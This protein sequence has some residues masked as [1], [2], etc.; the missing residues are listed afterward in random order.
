[1]ARKRR[2]EENGPRRQ[3]RPRPKPE[4]K[5]ELPDR[6][7]LE[8]TLRQF[9]GG[10]DPSTLKGQAEELLAQAFE[11]TDPQRKVELARKA[12]NLWP[13]CADAYVLLAE[14]ARSRKEAL[15]LYQQGVEAGQ[16]AL[17]P[18]VFEQDAGDFWGLLD[19]R[20]Y[21]RAREG[22]ANALWTAG[23]RQ[24][25]VEHLQEML[26]LNPHDNQGVRYTLARFLL[27]LDRD[28]D[29][30]HLL[31][32][33]PEE[34]SATWAYTEALLAFRQ[35]GDTP[36]ARRLLKDALRANR[37]LPD[38]LLD[39]KFPLAEPPGYYS[40]GD[41]SEA[42]YYIR[43][44]LLAWRSTPG[45]IAWLRANDPQTRKRK[46]QTP[47]PRGP[48]PLVKNWLKRK[49]PQQEEV[50]QADVRQL[51][52]AIRVAGA[53][54]RPWVVLVTSRTNDLVL[55]H[56]LLEEEPVAASRWD[57]LVQAMQNPVA[58]EPH[59]P[60]ELQVRTDERWQSLKPHIEEVAIG[61]VVAQELDQLDAVFK[62]VSEH[63]AGKPQPGLLDMPGMKPE[64][65][66]RFY[67]AAAEFFG[68]APWKQVGYEAAIRVQCDTYQSGPWYAVLMGQSGLT[69]GLAL[70]EDLQSLQQ[71]WEHPT[72]FEAHA[73]QSV[74]TT[75]IFGEEMDLPLADVEAVRRH[76]WKVARSD[77]WPLVMH[78]ERG[79]SHR[80]PLVWE[81]ELLEGCLRAVP[82]FVRHRPQNDPSPE[83]MSL[84]VASGE[85]KLVLSWV[86][87]ETEV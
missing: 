54:V 7:T 56:A 78:K 4:R 20:P 66:A 70:Y 10:A 60:T 13:D 18:G 36:G 23:R 68:Q 59:R 50:W 62:G 75:V 86:V 12:L 40:P 21:M 53:K 65:V 48:L 35:H 14:H 79:L 39:R 47:R 3:R 67:D 81:L 61:L 52:N 11:E 44:F 16:R 41:D 1:M 58:G 57:T 64:Q 30:S 42:L 46:E 51:P 15:Q 84:P 45:A 32:Q 8:R 2:P 9:V 27:F 34:G 76:G 63:I 19:T 49:L 17:G 24:E 43:D 83:E 73:R 31:G 69:T 28:R 37:H 85:L 71:G 29:L 74:A 55:A 22:L 6:R 33:F 77:A 38:Y 82:E 80:P 5:P 26:R 25:A 72:D 87:Q